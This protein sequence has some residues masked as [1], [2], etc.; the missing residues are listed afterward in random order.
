VVANVIAGVEKSVESDLLDQAGGAHAVQVR[1]LGAMT[2]SRD[3]QPL[4]LPSS[5]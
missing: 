2:I 5:R 3:G 4:T 1:M